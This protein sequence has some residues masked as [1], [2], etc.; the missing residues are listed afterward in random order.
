MYNNHE[1]LYIS[2]LLNH[3]FQ[4]LNNIFYYLYLNTTAAKDNSGQSLPTSEIFSYGYTA[5]EY[6]HYLWHD[7]PGL[8]K[9]GTY[10]SNTV[11]DGPY[12]EL[13][14]KP[15]IVWLKNTGTNANNSLTGWAIYDNKRPVTFNPNHSPMFANT[16]GSEGQRGD[17]SGTAGTTMYIDFL[18][19]GFKIRATSAECN[20]N[21][22]ADVYIY[23]AWAEAPTFN[24][25]GG[26]SNAR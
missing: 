4:N 15:A 1:L 5:N 7:V 9:F 2:I 20:T 23:C 24:L 17:A 3:Y 22:G 21:T 10:T 25:F 11:A 16:S 19:N 13:G 6:I 12:V 26:Q 14:F 8:Q 18:S